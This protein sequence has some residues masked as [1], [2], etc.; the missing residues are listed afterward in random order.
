VPKRAVVERDGRP[1]VFVV[2]E[3]RAEWVY[4]NAGRSNDRQTEVLPDSVSG[5]VPLKRGDIVLV[6][7]HLTLTHQAPVRLVSTRETE[8]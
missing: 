4:I 1:L 5:I 3:G 7:G 6:D 2:R 8:Q